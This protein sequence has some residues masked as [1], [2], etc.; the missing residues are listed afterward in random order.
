M[1]WGIIGVALG[2]STLYGQATAPPPRPTNL[3]LGRFGSI[4]AVHRPGPP[5][6]DAVTGLTATATGEPAAYPHPRPRLAGWSPLIAIATSDARRPV[7]D[8][9]FEHELQSTYVGNPLAGDPTMDYII[10]ILDSGSGVNLFAGTFAQ[11]L[12]LEGAFL[13]N[14]T[15]DVGGVGETVPAR[16]TWPVGFFAAGLSGVGSD[17]ALDLAAVVGHSSV[18]GL[19]IPPIICGGEEAVSG[20]LGTAFLSF[21]NTVVHVDQPQTVIHGG[22]TFFGPTVEVLDRFAPLP[23]YP[24]AIP[25][26]VGSFDLGVN[27][28]SYWPNL[29]DFEDQQTPFVPTQLSSAPGSIPFGGWFFTSVQ[30]L[31]GVPSPTNI[32]Q[33]F[34][35]LVDTGAQT[36]I[37][38][39]TTAAA[40]SLPVTPDFTIDVCGVGG[41]VSNIPGYYIDL[42]KI[43][44]LGG[45]LDYS[46]APFVVLDLAAP[47]GTAGVLP[48]IL[49]M[50]FFWNRNITLEPLL[51]GTSFLTVSEPVAFAGG[52]FNLDLHVDEN[53]LF[54]FV[55]CQTGP[56][57]G[58]LGPD[59]EHVDI[60]QDGVVDLGDF[61]TF[62]RC[63]SGASAE[64]DRACTSP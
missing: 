15:V 23:T 27:T 29:F 21:Y 60:D 47:D 61:S 40:L 35:M 51:T 3:R 45:A 18:S 22:R 42:V 44:A 62:Q 6:K 24:R 8:D 53:D 38:S 59:C 9:T 36:S 49:G 25:L 50:N 12:G 33:S 39:T 64:A 2:A 56:H 19:V 37:I 52:D 11:Q 55:A 17:G 30:L 34:R 54:D 48:G 58:L 13:T 28:A 26:E 57:S 14:N 5:A 63:F 7:F 10:G 32:I 41:F 16:L 46:R 4:V 31:E 1:F 43:N 20:V